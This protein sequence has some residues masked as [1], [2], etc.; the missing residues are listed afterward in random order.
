MGI[1]FGVM[2][3]HVLILPVATS[4]LRSPC[5]FVPLA[6]SAFSMA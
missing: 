1:G 6:A 3:G 4:Q 5:S 2:R